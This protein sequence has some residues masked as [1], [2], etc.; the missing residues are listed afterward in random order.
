MELGWE[1]VPNWGCLFVHRKQGLFLSVHVDD[2][3]MA[4]LKQNMAPMWKKL[5][6]NLEFLTIQLHFLT[7]FVWDALNVNANDIIIEE[8]SREFSA[9]ATQ[10]LPGWDKTHPKTGAWSYDM[11]GHAQTCVERHCERENKKTGA[12]VQK[13]QVLAWMITIQERGT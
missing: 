8:Y 2:I 6:K 3:Q 9:G 13:F 11:E 1:K 5:M 4:G 12:T 7:T 10:K